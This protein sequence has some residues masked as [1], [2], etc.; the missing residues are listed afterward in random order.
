MVGLVLPSLFTSPQT[1]LDRRAGRPDSRG[2]PRPDS[3]PPETQRQ[4]CLALRG[5]QNSTES[6]ARAPDS[7]NRIF[8]GLR[9][10]THQVYRVT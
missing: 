4:R 8:T 2:N 1:H 3:L 9:P 5:P 10:N 7:D 6:C